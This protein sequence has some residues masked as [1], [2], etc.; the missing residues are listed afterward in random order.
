MRVP[1]KTTSTITLIKPSELIELLNN[2]VMFVALIIVRGFDGATNDCVAHIDLSQTIKDGLAITI[3]I[4]MDMDM[5]IK[6][7]AVLSA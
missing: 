3:I 5:D 1:R 7:I 6:N 2:E 4:N